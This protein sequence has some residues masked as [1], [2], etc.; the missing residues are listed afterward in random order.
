MVS[1]DHISSIGLDNH[2]VK[3]IWGALQIFTLL[4]PAFTDQF[5]GNGQLKHYMLQASP[6]DD[7]ASC[8]GIA[9]TSL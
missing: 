8:D 4:D 9:A 3:G 2:L 1:A 5:K 6:A 7:P